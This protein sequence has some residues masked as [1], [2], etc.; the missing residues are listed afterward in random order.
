MI[1]GSGRSGYLTLSSQ[2]FCRFSPLRSY[3]TAT[4]QNECMDTGNLFRNRNGTVRC[5]SFVP[6]ALT[7]QGVAN[8]CQ[9]PNLPPQGSSCQEC[10]H[11]Q[12]SGCQSGM[13]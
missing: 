5:T 6:P 12:S 11:D 8:T 1:W 4:R 3:S 13:H 2:C 9:Q 10:A 7:V